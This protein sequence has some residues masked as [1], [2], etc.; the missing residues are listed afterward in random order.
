MPAPVGI[1][2][3]DSPTP[4]DKTLAVVDTA[5]DL[6]A[7]PAQKVG[8]TLSIINDGPGSVF[9]A[10]D[11]TAT[12]ADYEIKKNESYGEAGLDFVTNVSFIGDSG[13]KPRVR[14]IMWSGN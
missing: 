1:P 2:A 13:K 5:E 14:G 10:F 6:A 9:V 8:R 11:A 7:V 12:V 4:I 3:T